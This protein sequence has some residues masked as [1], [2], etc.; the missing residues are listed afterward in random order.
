MAGV[1]AFWRLKVFCRL[2][3]SIFCIILL[4]Q[5]FPC[6]HDERFL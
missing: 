3:F 4:K 2:T 5:A 1:F 6:Q